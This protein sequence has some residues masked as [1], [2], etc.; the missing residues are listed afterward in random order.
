MRLGNR[1]GVTP[2]EA[3]QG[4]EAA[5]MDLGVGWG[6]RRVGWG[7]IKALE[8]YEG[9]DWQQAWFAISDGDRDG[10]VLT[11]LN[12]TQ[13]GVA[14]NRGENPMDVLAERLRDIQVPN[15]G[16]HFDQIALAHPIHL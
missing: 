8:M 12:G 5:R 2:A 3:E 10:A 11:S 4:G 13:V 15:N 14:K 16:D 7:L 9:G 6:G 1:Q